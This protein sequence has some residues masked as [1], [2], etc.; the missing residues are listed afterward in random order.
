MTHYLNALKNLAFAFIALGAF[1]STSAFAAK[2]GF[3]A[4]TNLTADN[5]Y[6]GNIQLVTVSGSAQVFAFSFGGGISR[7]DDGINWSPKNNGLTGLAMRAVI[8]NNFLT[9]HVYAAT[10]DG[11]GFYKST[12]SG[13]TWVPLPA[14]SGLDCRNVQALSVLANATVPA[15]PVIFASTSCPGP[16]SG[17][18]KSVDG[19]ATWGKELSVPAGT[20]IQGG[21]T[22]ITQSNTGSLLYSARLSTSTGLLQTSNAT[23]TASAGSTVW[24][25]ING[26]GLQPGP[27]GQNGLYSFSSSTSTSGNYVMAVIQ[28]VGVFRAAAA[29]GTLSTTGAAV[30]APVLGNSGA[31]KPQIGGIF[32]RFFGSGA[33][34]D[35][36][37]YITIDGE[38]TYKSTDSGATWAL[39]PLLSFSKQIR[40]VTRD[41]LQT[42]VYWASTYHGLYKNT[43]GMTTGTWTKV[44]AAG[45]PGSY[46]SRVIAP[47]PNNSNILLSAGSILQRSTD[48]GATWSVVSSVPHITFASGDLRAAS[49]GAFVFASTA[50]GGIYK[51]VDG[52]STFSQ[53]PFLLTGTAGP[54]GARIRIYTSTVTSAVFATVGAS[55]IASAGGT[56]AFYDDRFDK[57]KFGL[58]RSFDFGSTWTNLNVGGGGVSAGLSVHAVSVAPGSA[59]TLLAATGSGIFKSTDSGGTWRL[60]GPNVVYAPNSVS[61]FGA[62]AAGISYVEHDPL[63][64][65]N[66]LAWANDLDA[67]NR[68]TALSG[69]YR[70]R[71]GGESWEAVVTHEK[72][73]ESR[74]T[75]AN[76]KSV[77]YVITRGFYDQPVEKTPVHRCPEVFTRAGDDLK[78]MACSPVTLQAM[79]D[80][81]AVYPSSFT[82][83]YQSNIIGIATATSGFQKFGRTSIGPDFNNDGVTDVVWRNGVSGQNFV[84]QMEKLSGKRT[85]VHQTASGFLPTV[86]TNWVIG[87]YGDFNGDG[88]TDVLWRN[89]SNGDNYIYLM[90]GTTVVAGSGFIL[91]VPTGWTVAGTGDFN[92]DGKDDILWRNTGGGGENYIYMMN[93]TA[94]LGSSGYIPTIPT[95]WT[96]ASTGDLDGNGTADIVWRNTGTGENYAYFMNGTTVSS[97][98]Y[99]PTVPTTWA[100]AGSSDL[101]GDGKYDLVWR[102]SAASGENYVYFMNGLSVAN[103]G[104]LP[105]IADTNW[106]IRGVGNYTDDDKARGILWYNTSTR[107][108]FLWRMNGNGLGIDGTCGSLGCENNA[109]FLPSAPNGW[110]VIHK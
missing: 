48:S 45:L 109:N 3:R 24:A 6:G 32:Q 86:P 84:W 46:L 15:S 5:A 98:G 2:E 36:N 21:V 31:P 70:S 79:A 61:S 89:T 69:V 87:G 101:D 103:Q 43:D 37:R 14:G 80:G 76:G 22:F 106:V 39:D 42:N 20:M 97:G 7:S 93:G 27:V 110:N 66:V 96:V 105:T 12:N 52:G 10:N 58:Y 92:G 82:I 23:G 4:S 88:N 35:Q 91:N 95:T 50:N 30:W 11:A 55:G 9:S 54:I 44:T 49:S 104:F 108:T 99:L 53:L 81:T 72:I 47:D 85:G 34:Q 94:L 28:G 17:L 16:S 74:F 63:N 77:P 13:D 102:N 100:V 40:N 26:T 18:Y 62:N 59:S 38:G 41:Q 71:D 90:D 1:A 56:G 51:S 68:A 107:S 73:S 33:T 78:N 19:G 57:A 83:G 60:V 67:A 75:V 65:N 8:T 25:S 64:A 29:G